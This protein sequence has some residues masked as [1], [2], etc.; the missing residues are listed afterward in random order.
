M[1]GRSIQNHSVKAHISN[2]LIHYWIRL[3]KEPIQYVAIEHIIKEEIKT[4]TFEGLHY[5]VFSAIALLSLSV[6][7]VANP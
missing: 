4:L 6:Y 7:F 3:Y 1:T 2:N 5:P